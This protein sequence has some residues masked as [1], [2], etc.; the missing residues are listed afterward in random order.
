MSSSEL[1][2]D[3]Q[4]EG[5]LVRARATAWVGSGGTGIFVRAIGTNGRWGNFDIA[6]LDR[7][8]LLSW[9]RGSI[10]KMER[11]LLLL[12]GHAVDP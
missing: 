2:T 10:P 9:M 6:E 3:P 1:R 8:S 5:L 12:L 4:R 11:T 7:E